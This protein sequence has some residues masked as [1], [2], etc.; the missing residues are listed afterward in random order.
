[1]SPVVWE[2]NDPNDPVYSWKPYRRDLQ[3]DLER[4]WG[5]GQSTAH[6]QVESVNYVVHVGRDPMVQINM[7]TKYKRQVRRRDGTFSYDRIDEQWQ[8]VNDDNRWADYPPDINQLLTESKHK[9]LPSVKFQVSKEAAHDHYYTVDFKM[10]LQ[11]NSKTSYKRAV[12][13]IPVYR[14][15][16]TWEWKDDN[17]SFH[18]Y[19]DECQELLENAYKRGEQSLDLSVCKRCYTVNFVRMLQTRKG[20]KTQ[21]TVI[22]KS[23]K[24][25]AA[26][27]ATVHSPLAVSPSQLTASSHAACDPE[28]MKTLQ[29][30]DLAQHA[31]TFAREQIRASEFCQLNDDDLEKLHIPLGHRKRLLSASAKMAGQGDVLTAK[32]EVP[33]EFYCPITMEL[34]TDPVIASDGFSYEREAIESWLRQKQ[35]SPMTNEP[36]KNKDLLPNRQLKKLIDDYQDKHG[37]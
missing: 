2:W 16:A 35:L 23:W 20:Y 34:M 8:W 31:E 13:C 11:I 9:Q 19:S 29:E 37:I 15:D 22:R 10:K 14:R 3:Q 36:L 1:M 27:C 12:R 17:G 30:L 21:R 32:D 18:S 28:L 6:F 33:N 24:P 25:T 5:S 4:A 7:K 26:S